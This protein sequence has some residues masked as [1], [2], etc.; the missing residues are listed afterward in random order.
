MLYPKGMDAKGFVERVD[1]WGAGYERKAMAKLLDAAGVLR[2]RAPSLAPPLRLFPLLAFSHSAS[3]SPLS[4][5]TSAGWTAVE[6]RYDDPW[7][8]FKRDTTEL[9]MQP[10]KQ[11]VDVK[12][13]LDDGSPQN[14]EPEEV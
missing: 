3:N 6:D 12:P 13:L 8:E 11:W 9:S 14:W 7:L 5:D 10:D 4:L 1:T 2:M